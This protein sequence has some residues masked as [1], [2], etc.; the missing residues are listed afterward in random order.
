MA[1]DG[2]STALSKH[3]AARAAI[4]QQSIRVWTDATSATPRALL[5]AKTLALLG[6][7]CSGR[8]CCSKTSHFVL[9]L[10]DQ[11]ERKSH[12]CVGGIE[13]ECC[14]D[15]RTG[16]RVLILSADG[17]RSWAVQ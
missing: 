13:E 17:I 15:T 12:L 1:V 11:I 6:P 7:Q 10:R 4:E 8:M 9:T 5:P 2:E 16:D 14:V 3:Y